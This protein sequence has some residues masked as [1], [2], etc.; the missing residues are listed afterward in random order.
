MLSFRE[1]PAPEAQFPR[2]LQAVEKV[3]VEPLGG[4]KRHQNTRNQGR[5]TTKGG[6]LSSRTGSESGNKG[7]FNSLTPSRHLGE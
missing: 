1:S 4:P 3:A 5:N 7:F 2:R 6:D